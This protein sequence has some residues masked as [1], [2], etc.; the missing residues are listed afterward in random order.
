[1]DLQ[2]STIAWGAIALGWVG[3]GLL[4]VAGF[5]KLR[6]PED[7]GEALRAA[8]LPGNAV[9]VRML[10]ITELLV[11]AG[12][13][14]VGGIWM[15]AVAVLYLGFT[16]FTASRLRTPSATCGCLGGDRDVPV[17]RMHVLVDLVIALGAGLAAGPAPGLAAFSGDLG[18]TGLLVVF[19]VALGV[20][21]V[22]LLLTELP[23]LLDAVHQ[24]EV[25]R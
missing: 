10:G 13:L 23:A 2:L 25:S 1:M 20:Q 11:G 24:V 14:L 3:A 15:A 8:G 7:T 18:T 21:S 5:A 16:A 19:C 22:R 12:A 4:L 17:T 9:V 6:Q